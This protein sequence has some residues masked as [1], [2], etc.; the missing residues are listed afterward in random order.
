MQIFLA[1]YRFNDGAIK[2]FTAIKAV[3]EAGWMIELDMKD[4]TKQFI[5]TA[6]GDTKTYLKMDSLI[7]DVE[8]ITGRVSS[9]ILNI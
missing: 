4:G 1:K 2:G 5:E 3:L 6:R 7:N 9:L 8:R